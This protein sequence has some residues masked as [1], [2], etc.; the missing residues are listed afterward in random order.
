MEPLLFIISAKMGKTLNRPKGVVFIITYRCN[1]RCLHCNLWRDYAN[2]KDMELKFD[3]IKR[4][5]IDLREFGVQE[6]NYS[7][8]EPLLKENFDKVLYFGYK[9]NFKQI[10]DT[11]GTLIDE[12]WAEIFKKYDINVNLSLEGPRKINDLIRGKGHFDS[13]IRAI[14]LLKDKGLIPHVN[15]T[16]AKYNIKYLREFCEIIKNLNVKCGFQ[17][18][19]EGGTVFPNSNPKFKY[20]YTNDEIQ[21]VKSIIKEYRDIIDGSD[22]YYEE[23]LKYMTGLRRRSC[24]VAYR[25]ITIDPMGYVYPCSFWKEPIGHISQGIANIWYS[26]KFETERRK[27]RQCNKCFLGCYEPDN[28]TYNQFVKR[29]MNTIKI[30]LKI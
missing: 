21:F 3:D 27:M 2:Y 11:N 30:K 23:M 9:L 24:V 25:R 5:L 1:L 8:G 18:I 15:L 4:L 13:T 26:E 29:V 6:I 28:I 10:V 14:E 19:V 20:H 16:L 22:L 17:P 7:G 12:Y